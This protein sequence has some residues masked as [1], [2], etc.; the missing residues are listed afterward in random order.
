MNVKLAAVTLLVA[1]AAAR[2]TGPSAA[3][4]LGWI[5][6]SWCGGTENERLEEYWMP[7]AGGVLLGIGRRVAAQRTESFEFMRIA[8][9]DGAATYVA[10]PD[11][12]NPVAFTRTAGGSD[13]VR[14]ENRAHDFPTRVEYRRTADG[15]HAEI[16]G[17]GVEGSE[18]VVP[19]DYAPCASH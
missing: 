15:L 18:T 1:A 17:P 12:G 9:A 2:G 19:F 10:H 6:G 16:A 13:W 11:G 14:F 3:L 4:D 5:S 7:P 8:V